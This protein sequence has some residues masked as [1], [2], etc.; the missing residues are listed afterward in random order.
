MPQFSGVFSKLNAL[1]VRGEEADKGAR[2][3]DA[4]SEG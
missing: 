1:E 4:D 3:Y 2:A